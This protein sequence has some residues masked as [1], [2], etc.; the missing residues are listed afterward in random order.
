M[1]CLNAIKSQNA[2]SV[3]L[4]STCLSSEIQTIFIFC[5]LF[6][7][8]FSLQLFKCQPLYYPL[9][10]IIGS[11]LSWMYH[12]CTVLS[13]CTHHFALQNT[14]YKSCH[15]GHCTS[16]TAVL[17]CQLF[18]ELHIF[19]FKISLLSFLAD[20]SWQYFLNVRPWFCP[21]HYLLATFRPLTCTAM[22]V[23]ST[24]KS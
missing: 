14:L 13:W 6:A 15:S 9:L 23:F 20:I 18:V 4:F 19:L 7:H 12:H 17:G 5:L 16:T 3:F 22:M 11:P 1:A 10:P 24:A 2:G 8:H 21:I